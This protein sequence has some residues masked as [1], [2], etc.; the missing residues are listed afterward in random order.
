MALILAYARHHVH[1]GVGRRRFAD[2][3]PDR[4]RACRPSTTTRPSCASAAGPWT[5]W[6]GR[7]AA[8]TT[9]A[10]PINNQVVSIPFLELRCHRTAVSRSTIRSQP[11][12]NT[13]N[14]H[15]NNNESVLCARGVRHHG[16]AGIERGS[17][18]FERREGRRLRQHP[19]PESERRGRGQQHRL[20]ARRSTTSSRR[21]YWRTRAVATGYRPGSYNPRPF[22]AT[23]VVAVDA[24]GLRGL[25]ARLEVRLVRPAA[26]DQPRRVLYGLE[27]AHHCRW[28]APS[29]WSATT[30]GRRPSTYRMTPNT[31][32]SVTDSL[33]NVCESPPTVP[34]LLREHAGRGRGR[35]GRGELGA[36]RR[37]AV[38]RR[39]RLD[40]LGIAR[41][42]RRSRPCTSE[43][44]PYV[45]EDNWA[46]S[47]SYDMALGSG[48]SLTPRVDVYGQAEICSQNVFTTSTFPERE[49]HG[50]L[51]ADERAPGV[52]A[53]PTT[54]GRSRWAPP[55]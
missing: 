38:Q 22:Q 37:A 26:A 32:G 3:R 23:Q 14:V 24:R 39:L 16:Q 13:D 33:G 54:S 51:R 11:F 35:R 50:C 40:R 8:S 20:Q 17:P 49:L 46:L 30:W 4:Q 1:A 28:A 2:Q 21:T 48:A 36:D 15:E 42:Q 44:P 25:R 34:D 27:D 45:P 5:G 53:A 9:T 6:T 10:S 18:L 29:A 43:R 7:S 31:P 47:A 55:T 19:G 12:V 52:A 41:H